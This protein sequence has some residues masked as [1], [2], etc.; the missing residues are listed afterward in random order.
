[1]KTIV[2]NHR[3]A[4]SAALCAAFAIAAAWTAAAQVSSHAEA[5][6]E[7]GGASA[8]NGVVITSP[9]GGT[10]AVQTAPSRSLT[11]SGLAINA[12][13]GPDYERVLRQVEAAMRKAMDKVVD[14]E[15]ME[16]ALAEARRA[17][18]QARTGLGSRGAIQAWGPSAGRAM[19][20]FSD[21]LHARQGPPE[22]ALVLTAPVS[23]EIRGE[24]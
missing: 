12:G 13:P 23:P 14:K 21:R 20:L 19:N 10:V 9:G 3:T 2:Q 1:M 18:E 6:G 15:A 11:A 4:V 5:S 24:G 22:P 7:A 17:L 16:K 8:G